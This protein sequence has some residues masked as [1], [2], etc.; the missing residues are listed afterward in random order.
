MAMNDPLP[1]QHKRRVYTIPLFAGE[2]GVSE[3]TVWR[4]IASQKIKT[5]K[6]SIGR[7]GIPAE[8]L[9]RIAAQ[10]IAR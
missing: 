5:I 6:I 3:R 9:E 10:G 8:E 1:P 4:L 2:I 7:T